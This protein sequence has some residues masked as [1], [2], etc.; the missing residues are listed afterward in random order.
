MKTILS[1]LFVLALARCQS[2]Q[3]VPSQNSPTTASFPTLLAPLPPPDDSLVLAGIYQLQQQV[4]VER[5]V[6]ALQLLDSI[7]CQSDGYL[8]E[9]ISEA[10]AA[11]WA[12]Q[13]ML[14]LCYL[15]QHPKA[16]L[17]QAVVLGIS[18]DISTEE[19]RVQALAN[20]RQ[21]ALDSGR[22]AGLSGRE[23][24]FLQ[25]FISEVNPALLD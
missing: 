22:R 17:R 11:I 10:A 8:S 19:N 23:M 20:F 12:Q 2:D 25:Q 1:A 4:A 3:T 5:S 16:C 18:A 24:L 6:G 15:E 7:Y 14:T 21:T 13:S 9:G